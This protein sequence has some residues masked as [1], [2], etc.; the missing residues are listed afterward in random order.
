MIPHKIR[1]ETVVVGAARTLDTLSQ[2]EG[3]KAPK[4]RKSRQQGGLVFRFDR[5]CALSVM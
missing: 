1:R 3:Y 2:V 4:Y 5:K